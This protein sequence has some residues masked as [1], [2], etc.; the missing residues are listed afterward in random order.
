[1]LKLCFVMIGIMVCSCSSLDQ[2]IGLGVGAGAAT[3]FSTSKLL[4][5]NTKGTLVLTGTGA[6]IGGIIGLLVHP[7]QVFDTDSNSTAIYPSLRQSP[8]I[9]NAE[10]DELWVPDSIEGEKFIEGHKVHI[11]KRPAHWQLY[12]EKKDRHERD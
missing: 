6:L 8:P 11:I 10:M 3:G 4:H 5:Y 1:M 12:P 9:R 2:S 7:K